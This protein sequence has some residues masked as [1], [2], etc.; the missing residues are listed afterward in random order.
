MKRSTAL[1]FALGM[2]MLA[3]S[4]A[5]PAMAQQVTVTAA[6]VGKVTAETVFTK[7]GLSAALPGFLVSDLATGAEGAPVKAFEA[8]R[9]GRPALRIFEG[10][11]GKV[12]RVLVISAGIPGPGNVYVGASLFN[13]YGDDGAPSCQP[14]TEEASGKVLCPAPGVPAVTYVFAGAWSGPDGTLPPGDVLAKWTVEAILWKA[15]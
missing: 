12:G 5:A 9:G 7:E 2:G 13:A 14:G 3:A 10:A 4:G 8:K 11:P 6:G 1:G 15:N